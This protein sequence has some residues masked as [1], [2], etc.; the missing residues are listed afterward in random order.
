MRFDLRL[1]GVTAAGV[2]CVADISVYATSQS[3]LQKQ[4]DQAARTAAWLMAEAPHEPITEG[5]QISVE[6]VERL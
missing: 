2:K 4:A 3:D 6:H 5:S 1:H